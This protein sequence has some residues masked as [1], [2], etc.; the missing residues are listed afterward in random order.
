MSSQT[1]VN[2]DLA[3]ERKTASFDRE[4]LTEVIYGG[5]ESVRR[6][7]YLQNLAI[8]DRYLQSFPPWWNMDRETQYDVAVKKSVYLNSLVQKLNLKNGAEMFYLKEA[9]SNQETNPLG[10]HQIMFIPTIEKQG[11]KEQIEKYV[12]PAKQFKILGTYAQTELG[13]GTFIRGLETMATYDPASEEFV[14]NSP[15]ITSMKYWPGSLGKTCNYVILMAQ[16]YTKGKK[17]GIHA[18]VVQIRSL[19][20]HKPMPGVTLG[21]IGNKLGYEGMDNGFLMFNN[22]RVPRDAMLMRYAKVER[23]GT[24]VAPR[25]AKIAYGSMVYIRALIVGDMGRSCA[26]ASTIATRYSAVRRQTEIRPGGPEP[27]VIDYQTQQEKLFPMIAASYGL[28]FTGIFMG[29]EYNRVTADIEKGNLEEMQSLHALAAGLKALSSDIAS[30]GID[31]LRRACGGHGYTNA[32]GLGKIWANITPA[33]TYEGENTV[34]YLQCARYL[35]KV[36]ALVATGKQLPG[37]M[38]YLNRSGKQ[39]SS[40]TQAL[41][42]EDFVDLYEHTAARL[43]K[44]VAIRLQALLKS[45]T[46]VEEARNLCGVQMVQAAKMHSY[47]YTVRTFNAVIQARASDPNVAKALTSLCQLFAVNGILQRLG[48]FLQDGY[49]SGQQA[50]MLADKQLALFADIRPNAVALVD[51][52]DYPDQ[53]LGSCLG[54]YDGNVYE[55]LYE[56]AKNSPLN[57]QDVLPSYYTTLKPLMSGELNFDPPTARM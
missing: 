2:P 49:L 32:S 9:A 15:T 22:Y 28:Y 27:Q 51:A 39:Q 4:N 48:D 40:L 45:G 55:A 30:D 31:K 26:Q 33:C 37:F 44:V 56:Y 35:V 17:M 21:D 34:M 3:K 20:D 7:R 36:Y 42:M 53:V 6:R 1:S 23:D 46:S 16:L 14:I 11:T 41:N 54:R 12:T 50:A 38:S 52:F 24:Y 18:F 19:Q 43:I 10:L 57:K 47:A 25:N 5:K 13:H 8:Q 29:L